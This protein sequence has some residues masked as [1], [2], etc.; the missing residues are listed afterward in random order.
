MSSSSLTTHHIINKENGI[1]HQLIKDKGASITNCTPIKKNESLI[2]QAQLTKS[3]KDGA[4]KLQRRA[5]GDVLNTTKNRQST[6]TVG[7]TPKLAKSSQK[8]PFIY[9]DPKPDEKPQQLST[10]PTVVPGLPEMSED[11]YLNEKHHHNVDT[12]NDLFDE[13][14]LSDMFLNKNVKFRPCLP[15]GDVLND[16]DIKKPSKVSA[17]QVRKHF[18]RMDKSMQRLIEQEN[19]VALENLKMEMPVWDDEMFKLPELE[20]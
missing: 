15:A 5:L 6:Q 12:L 10:E 1:G 16:D 4:Q 14:K 18:N 13:G 2:Q 17:K 20:F 7:S 8:T 9:C 11:E 19:Q 3:I